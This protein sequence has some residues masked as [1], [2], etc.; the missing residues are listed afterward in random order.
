M[1]ELKMIRADL[2]YDFLEKAA[3]DDPKIAKALVNAA[4]EIKYNSRLYDFMEVAYPWQREAIKMTA[5]HRVVGL[6]AANQVGKSET[7]MSIVSCLATGIVPQWWEGRKYDR[8]VK[9]MVAGVD[10]NHNKNVLQDK[11]IGTNNWRMKSEVGSGQ[12]PKDFIIEDSG[13]TVRG[14]DLSVLFTGSRG[15]SG[16]PS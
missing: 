12:V 4:K 6:I 15:G 11:L 16:L 8:P 2:D 5:N 9:I 13:V 10:S 1:S 7:A 3:K 14:D